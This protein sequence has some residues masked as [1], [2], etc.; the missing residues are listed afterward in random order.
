VLA[1]ATIFVATASSVKINSPRALLGKAAHA[2]SSPRSPDLLVL[3][4]SI[5]FPRSWSRGVAVNGCFL[6]RRTHP[7][8]AQRQNQI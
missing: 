3:A 7:G 5:V 1:A 6:D 4:H 8:V 2:P